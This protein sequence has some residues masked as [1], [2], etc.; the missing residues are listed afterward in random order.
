MGHGFPIMGSTKQKLKSCSSTETEVISADN[1]MPEICST[2]YFM[3]AQG[4]EV[5][6]NILFQ[7][8]MSSILLKKNGK[9]SSSRSTKHKNIW[10]FFITDRVNKGEVSVVW[11]PTG[12]MIAD[13]ATKPLQGALFRKFRDQIMGVVKLQDPGLPK[14]KPKIGKI[15]NCTQKPRKG[16]KTD[17]VPPQAGRHHRSVL[18]RPRKPTKDGLSKVTHRL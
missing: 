14:P 12:D 1:F 4:Y 13:Y 16:K 2:R 8:N 15:D 6:D 9:A 3:E 5:W 18:G 7:D 17:M 11:C 10:H